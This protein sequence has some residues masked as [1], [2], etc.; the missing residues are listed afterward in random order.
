MKKIITLFVLL[1]AVV[2][3]AACGKVEVSEVNIKNTAT[4]IEVGKS[5]TLEVEVLPADAADKKVTYTSDKPEFATVSDSGVVLGVAEGVVVITAKA[6]K[7]SDTISLTVTAVE[8]EEIEVASVELTFAK[9]S[10]DIDETLQ[11]TVV[12]LPSE[13]PQAVVYKSSKPAVATVSE[14]GLVKAISAGEVVITAT[15]GTKSKTVTLTVK[16]AEVIIPDVTSIVLTFPELT[17]EKGATLQA[18]TKVLPALAVQT[19]V[20]S[21]SDSS[22]ATISESGLLTALKAGEVTITATAVGG[23]TSEVTIEVTDSS[24]ISIENLKS[25]INQIANSYNTSLTGFIKMRAALGDDVLN[26]EFAYNYSETG[27]NELMYKQVGTTESHIYVKDQKVYMLENAVKGQSPLSPSEETMLKQQYG[28]TAFTSQMLNYAKDESFFLN[29]SLVGE[30]EGVYTFSLNLE[31]Y[32]GATFDLAGKDAISLEVTAIDG[33]IS[34]IELKIANSN[35]TNGS[36]S[37]E[38]LGLGVPTI[39]FP[40]DLILYPAN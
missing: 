14:T 27:I 23:L 4:T 31:T 7:I 34:K 39:P 8:E 21:S 28:V 3:L 1:F 18:L 35:G 30:V 36:T 17:V 20:Y 9:T 10:L 11:A 29:L 15:A 26:T 38:F 16:A 6:G 5:L 25:R 33:A 40:S 37:I 22:I 19:V 24:V 12:V 32:D 2:A 13:A